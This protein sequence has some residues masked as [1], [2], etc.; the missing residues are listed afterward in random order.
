MIKTRD[1]IRL[2]FLENLWDRY[3]EAPKG[4]L[5]YGRVL[6]GRLGHY[7]L[8]EYKMIVSKNKTNNLLNQ[9]EL[10]ESDLK[11]K[12]ILIDGDLVALLP[13]NECLL[14]ASNNTKVQLNHLQSNN[15]WIM[16]KKYFELL[17]F[18]RDHLKEKKF[19]ECKNN[20]YLIY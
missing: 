5:Q 6:Q 10:Q 18:I 14:L 16:K 8:A 11:G 7:N 15:P 20:I 9:I 2:F 1:D 12:N 19:F 3:P 13:G 17:N 4:Y